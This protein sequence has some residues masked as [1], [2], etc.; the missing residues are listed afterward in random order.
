MS[1]CLQTLCRKT[2]LGF[3]W[4]KGWRID[5]ADYGT[6]LR[7]GFGRNPDEATKTYVLGLFSKGFDSADDNCTALHLAI[8]KGNLDAAKA[9]LEFGANANATDRSGLT[10][11][12]YAAMLDNRQLCE[13]LIEH[14]ANLKVKDADGR[15]P[16]DFAR[17]NDCDFAQRYLANRQ[18]G[19]LLDIHKPKLCH[20]S[21]IWFILSE[22]NLILYSIDFRINFVLASVKSCGF[23]C[24][25]INSFITYLL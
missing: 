13:L 15:M 24:W 7:S 1:S 16:L 12:H 8:E 10:P 23:C 4:S 3:F 5:I 2:I 20:F 25:P 9:L 14:G 21:I 6:I 22:I 17:L 11:L 19:T 18:L